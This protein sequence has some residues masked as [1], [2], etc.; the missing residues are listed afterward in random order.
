MEQE[1]DPSYELPWVEKYRPLLVSQIV[2]NNAVVAQ[3]M[4]IAH[5]GNMPNLILSVSAA[6]LRRTDNL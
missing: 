1:V 3:L 5:S 6:F 2:G 4:R